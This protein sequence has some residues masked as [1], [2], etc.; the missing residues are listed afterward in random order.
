MDLKRLETHKE[1]IGEKKRLY[2]AHHHEDLKSAEQIIYDILENFECGCYIDVDPLSDIDIDERKAYIQ[3]MDIIVLVVTK[4]F[5]MNSNIG[6]NTD[7]KIAKENKLIVLPI[8]IES[9]LQN[10]FNSVVGHYH[11]INKNNSTYKEQLKD[12]FDKNFNT[13]KRLIERENPY[14]GKVFISY[15]KK[16][17]VLL[18]KL[19]D[20]ISN[21]NYFD[22][23]EIWYDDYLIPGENYNE[24]IEE[25]I[26]NCD[27]VLF[28]ITENCLE[29]NNYIENKEYPKAVQYRKKIIPVTFDDIKMPYI[30][31]I[32]KGLEEIIN[33]NEN[34]DVLEQ[35]IR[36][37]PNLTKI[38]VNKLTAEEMGELAI[39]H[40]DNHKSNKS[41]SK[42]LK[43]LVSAA[44]RRYNPA[45]YR[46]GNLYL[47]GIM[48]EKNLDKALHWLDKSFQIVLQKFDD[49]YNRRE[50]E[51]III[52]YGIS[53]AKNALQLYELLKNKGI[54][55]NKYLYIY[56]D[57][58][59]KMLDIGYMSD[60]INP[61]HASFLKSQILLKEGKA[62]E[63][64]K[65]LDVAEEYL[66]YL[67]KHSNNPLS[68]FKY[69]E[70][71]IQ[72]AEVYTYI[73]DHFD[74]H[75]MYYEVGNNLLQALDVILYLNK[76]FQ[77]LYNETVNILNDLSAVGYNIETKN[78]D[79]D[80][81]RQLYRKIYYTAKDF[82][83]KSPT[84]EVS[85]R[86]ALVGVSYAVVGVDMPN[87]DILKEAHYYI[88]KCLEVEVN[89][90][91][92]SLLNSIQ[93]RI[94]V[95]PHNL[96]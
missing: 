19:L 34:S 85:F 80:T 71:L 2:I 56:F 18:M 16:D 76:H 59:K 58:T 94:E 51:N 55:D 67:Y 65:Q 95:W 91:Y 37:I 75:D 23:L 78:N 29:R 3:Q 54:S 93:K 72:K 68:K 46:L 73:G 11:I 30:N 5:L 84:A 44:K 63:S 96:G 13:Y 69:M 40:L 32:Y 49:S 57:I 81:A 92:I 22:P 74:E 33:L 62:F 20:Y 35:R 64:I 90:Q 60:L 89:P 26:R 14:K 7:F 82:Y 25:S 48:L 9:N 41:N 66:E 21:L 15:R 83:R 6:L 27:F 39:D 28:L 52:D 50:D 53:A 31:E 10:E 24:V 8:L 87:L 88:N 77:V 12:F 4:K 47:E 86:I 45:M 61:G 17:K 1:I 38:F 42:G 43:L 70:F 79:L 36:Y